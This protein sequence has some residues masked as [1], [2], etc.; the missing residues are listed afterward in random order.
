MNLNFI[1]FSG[2]KRKSLSSLRGLDD[3]VSKTSGKNSAMNLDGPQIVKSESTSDL[4]PVIAGS[5]LGAI[6]L[7]GIGAVI[8]FLYFRRR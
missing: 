5:V 7:I 4:T 3:N 6:V 1:F 2:K 8:G